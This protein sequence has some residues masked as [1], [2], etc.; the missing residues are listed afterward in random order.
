MFI[1]FFVYFQNSTFIWFKY[2]AYRDTEGLARTHPH[3]LTHART[4]THTHTHTHHDY[5]KIAPCGMIKV[6][7][8]ELN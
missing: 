7:L 8:T 4:H 6:F 2:Y 1:M 3:A 5:N